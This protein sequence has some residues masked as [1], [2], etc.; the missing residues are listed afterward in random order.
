MKTKKAAPKVTNWINFATQVA[1]ILSEDYFP[2]HRGAVRCPSTGCTAIFGNDGY[3]QDPSTRAEVENVR[4]RLNAEGITEHAFAVN[5]DGYTWV[6][7]AG[8]PSDCKY[9][10][11]MVWRV[12][13]E[14]AFSLPPSDIILAAGYGTFQGREAAQVLAGVKF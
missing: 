3:T 4:R 11:A 5:S 9:L 8:K 14:A 1:Q 7:L 13:L 2:A 6:L 12:W 10:N